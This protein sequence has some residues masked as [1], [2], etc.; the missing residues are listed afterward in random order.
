MNAAS[1]VTFQC[2]LEILMSKARRSKSAAI[3]AASAPAPT[4]DQTR[5][6]L[7]HFWDAFSLLNAAAIGMAFDAKQS[8]EDIGI[9]EADAVSFIN[10]YNSIILRAPGKGP[11]VTTAL[12]RAWHTKAMSV[13]AKEITSR[14][15]P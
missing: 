7:I 5:T 14:A 3:L 11:L 10:K 9:G 4:L 13:V 8:L 12:A 1:L 6:E 2:R 15:A